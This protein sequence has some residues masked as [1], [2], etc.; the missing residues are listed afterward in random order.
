M[1][2]LVISHEYP[3]IGGGGANACMFLTREF[4]RAGHDVTIL[5]ARYKGA[6]HEDGDKSV[7]GRVEICR[8]NCLR[9]KVESSS[10]LE[11]LTFLLSAYRQADRLVR[12]NSFDVCLVFFGIPSGPIALHLKRKYDLP[13]IIRSGGGDIPGTQKRFT[14][15]YKILAPALRTIWREA[16]AIV[17]NSEGLRERALAF[18]DRYPIS[19]IENGVDTDFFHPIDDRAGTDGK[20]QDKNTV[21]VLFVSRLLE[22]K[23]LQFIIPQLNQIQDEVYASCHKDIELVVVGDGPYRQQLENLAAETDCLQRIRFEGQKN[24]QEVGEYYQSSDIF[25]LPSRWEGMP[26]VVLEAMASGLPIIMTPCEGSK[27]LVT[28]NGYIATYEEM[29]DRIIDLCIHEEKRERMGENSLNR[30]KQDYQWRAIAERYL[31]MMSAINK[32]T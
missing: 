6:E 1:K 14:L 27:E 13:Y 24:K 10:F 20:N 3:P 9:K 26:N 22:R 2:I 29:T 15:M 19:V 5:T 7:A 31:D 32:E 30:V 17:A 11:M 23:G 16:S 25:L 12:K 18:E 21:R 28:D 4:A 8:V